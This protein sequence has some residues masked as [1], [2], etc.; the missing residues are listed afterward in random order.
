MWPYVRLAVCL[1]FFVP[2][3]ALMAAAQSGGEWI[4]GAL[5]GLFFALVFGGARWK[6]LSATFPPD[7]LAKDERMRYVLIE[8]LDGRVEVLLSNVIR[9]GDETLPET[10]SVPFRYLGKTL[11]REELDRA[12]AEG[13]PEQ[14]S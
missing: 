6:W 2:A 5:V 10:A 9:N 8:R 14:G 11:T 7:P 4:I 3:F 12:I 1:V 13:T